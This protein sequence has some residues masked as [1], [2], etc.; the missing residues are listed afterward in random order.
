[1][2]VYGIDLHVGQS[3]DGFSF[4][5]CSHEYFV[6]PSKKD[7]RTHTLVFLLLEVHVVCELYLGYS[8]LLG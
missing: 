5:L 6:P 3:L 8:E 7:Q 2:I 4:S 1:M